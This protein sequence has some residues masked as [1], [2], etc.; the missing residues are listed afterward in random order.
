GRKLGKPKTC[1][2]VVSNF[3]SLIMRDSH[4]LV[5][6]IVTFF[7]LFRSKKCDAVLFNFWNLLHVDGSRMQIVVRY[8]SRCH[9][10]AVIGNAC[11]S[12]LPKKFCVGHLFSHASLKHCFKGLFTGLLIDFYWC[13]GSFSFLP[14]TETSFVD[15]L[16]RGSIHSIFCDSSI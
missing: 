3:C 14:R 16:P 12:N 5:R 9:V 11:G 15:N 2:K 1:C 13:R 10:N 8:T 4:L 7:A 6:K